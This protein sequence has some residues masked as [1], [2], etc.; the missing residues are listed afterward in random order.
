MPDPAGPCDPHLDLIR[1]QH[2]LCHLTKS[3]CRQRKIKIV[4]IGSSSTAGEN[5]VIP[6]PDRL[7]LALRN[8]FPDRMIDVLNR[9]IGGQE[10]P[11][12][13]ARFESDVI[14]E[15]PTLVIWQ[16]GT[17]AIYHRC[18]YDPHRVATTIATGVSWLKG[19]ETDVVLM[20][21]QYAPILLE[22]HPDDTRL[23]VSLISAV[24]GASG[25]NLFPRFALMEQWEKDDGIKPEALIS[26]D[27]LHQT[28]FATNCVTQALDLAIGSAVGA[29]PTEPAV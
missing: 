21:L 24:A 29:I 23:M 14:A 7:E 9:G 12:E 16:V 17:N 3:L 25:I 8:R 6:F 18:L 19:L 13:L 10:A 11:E 28:D 20:D 15:A 5:N 2:R 4:A 26:A 22:K 27:G 1:F